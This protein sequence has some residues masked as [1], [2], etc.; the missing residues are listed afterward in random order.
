M[1]PEPER[2]HAAPLSARIA[3]GGLDDALT[4]LLARRER[5]AWQRGL[6]AGRSAAL[7]EAVQRLDLAAARFDAATVARDA[8]LA[9]DVVDLALAIGSELARCEIRAGRH[10]IEA[11]VRETLAASNVGRG[12]CKVHLSPSDAELLAAVPFRAATV[13]ESDIDVPPGSVQVETPQGLLVRDL[14]AAI[15]SIGARLREEIQ[16]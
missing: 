13:I 1:S 16:A 11:I 6:Q 12:A 5:E 4:R 2:L 9:A 7:L 3:E 8:A 14:A 15:A 10:G